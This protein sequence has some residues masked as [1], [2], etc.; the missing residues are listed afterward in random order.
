MNARFALIAALFA[1]S[2]TASSPAR[3]TTADPVAANAP[4][5]ET[6]Q[7][8]PAEPDVASIDRMTA[9]IMKMMPIDR[10]FETVLASN[11]AELKSKLDAT[12]YACLMRQ[13]GRDALIARKRAEVERFARAKPEAFASG[14][15]VLDDGAA[16]LIAKT[17]EANF[18]GTEMD[19]N[20]SEGSA[21]AA[22]AA[23]VFDERMADLRN[24]SGFGDINAEKRSGESTEAAI[25]ALA[26]DVGET[27]D[28]PPEVLN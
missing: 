20:R 13:L 3:A 7:T 8:G 18:A 24:L 12:Q 16:D 2:A 28:I 14:L 6:L 26:A 1:F 9:H 22:F 11:Q 25:D 17:V 4:S 27:C 5:N 23:F 21:V 10:I 15:K 19:I